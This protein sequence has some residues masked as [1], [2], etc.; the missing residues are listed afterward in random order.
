MKPDIF[1]GDLLMPA[2]L[3]LEPWIGIKVTPEALVMM[4]AIAGQESEWMYRRQIGGPARGYWQFEKGGGTNGVLS[5]AAS[6]SRAKS[7]CSHLDIPSDLDTVFEALAWNDIL[8]PAMARLL[9][10]TDPRPLPQVGS[11]QAAWDY[12]LSIW[13]PGKPHPESWPDRYGVAMEL[14]KAEAV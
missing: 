4:M 14:V 12:Y 10:W 7:V 9:L 1:Y 3:T 8:G 13:R 5:H 2:L 11:Q 6:S